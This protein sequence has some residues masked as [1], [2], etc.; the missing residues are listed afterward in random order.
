[1]LVDNQRN[2][3]IGYYDQRNNE[4]TKYYLA[5][6]EGDDFEVSATKVRK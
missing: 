3:K 6:A 1:M 2:I 4:A 5:A